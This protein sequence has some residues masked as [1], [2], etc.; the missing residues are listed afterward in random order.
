MKLLAATGSR[1][2]A[3]AFLLSLALVGSAAAQTPD[4]AAA[5]GGHMGAADAMSGSLAKAVS[6]STTF[7]STGATPNG[8][9]IDAA[10]NVYTANTTAGTV[11]MISAD[12]TSMTLGTT[13]KGPIGIAVDASG[14]IYTANSGDNT[15]TKITPSGASSTLG[16]TGNKPIGITVDS[17]GNVY[18]TNYLDS[19]VTKITPAGVISTLALTGEH[20]LGIT[21]DGSGNIYTANEKTNNVTKITA[22]GV[23]STLGTTGGWPQG[24]ALDG[25]NNVYTANWNT[26][27]VSKITQ[28]GVSS[29]LGRTGRRPIGIA[30]DTSGNVYTTNNGSSDV[31]RIT[32]LGT[33]QI[34]GRTGRRPNGIRVNASGDVFTANE[35][36]KTVTKIVPPA[37]S[38]ANVVSLSTVTVAAPDN[39]AVWIIPFYNAVYATQKECRQNIKA[40]R[41]LPAQAGVGVQNVS[42][43]SCMEVGNVPY[44]FNI[45]ETEVTV[46]QW[47]TF[48]NTVDPMGLNR[49]HL[50]A[51]PNGSKVWPLYGSINRTAKALPGRHYSVASAAWAQKPFNFADFTRSARFINSLQNGKTLST[52]TSTVTTVS[53]ATLKTTTYTVRL[54]KQTETGMYT[55][56]DRSATRNLD[57]GFAVTSQDEWMKAAYFDPKGGG[58]SSYWDYP[59]GPGRFLN[60]PASPSP[61][62]DSPTQCPSM[63][64]A[65]TVLDPTTGN[66]TN[67]ATQPLASYKGTATPPYWC[68]AQFTA[69]QCAITPFK[70]LASTYTGNLSTVG[71]AL[72]RSPWGTLDQGGNTVE[73]TDT[74][75]P[76]PPLQRL[77]NKIVWR[78]WHGGVVTAT[79]YQMWLSAVGVTPQTIPGYSI[80]PWRGLRIAVLG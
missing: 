3:L 53:G 49:H 51:A 43:T 40:V 24:I 26:R 56:S 29:I 23:A 17:S 10:G 13:G 6:N 35:L 52:K 8:L 73:I 46:A 55:M 72:T 74:I 1:V 76:P 5:I 58:Q 39:A 62:V 57:S 45:G 33:S 11:T 67:G 36:S 30:L 69:A 15:V 42:E 44:T 21:V 68:A 71:Q 79:D 77:N 9:V 38:Q 25:S 47:T 14:N 32:T 65:Q 31:S 12:G 61:T 28:A 16:T 27:N 48:L 2:V 59:T 7:G 78:R 50:W 70:P 80:N 63:P 64:P 4:L 66:V 34:I 19:T 54:S 18:T 37:N 20:P 60:C 41:A 22:A 75:A